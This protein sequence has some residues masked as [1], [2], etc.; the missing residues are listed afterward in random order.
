MADRYYDAP[1]WECSDCGAIYHKEPTPTKVVWGKTRSGVPIQIARAL[2]L[3]D[4]CGGNVL[5]AFHRVRPARSVRPLPY[6]KGMRQFEMVRWCCWNCGK[7]SDVASTYRRIWRGEHY[8]FSF[9]E[10][11]HTCG[12]ENRVAGTG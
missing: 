8:S 1:V 7:G 5:R 12:V 6:I 11:C 3:C 2:V 10:K 4:A 9:I